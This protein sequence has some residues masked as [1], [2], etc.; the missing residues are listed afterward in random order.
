MRVLVVYCFY[1]K[2]VV[3]I[4]NLMFFL[5][6]CVG[7]GA[8]P[9]FQLDY[10]FCINGPCDID[11]VALA[12]ARAPAGSRVSS[13]KRPNEDYDFGAYSDALTAVSV[14]G[15]LPSYD[16]YF[17]LNT[18]VRGPFVPPYFKGHWLDPFVDLLVGDVHLC[19]TTINVLGAIGQS[20]EAQA[21]R[22]VT[23]WSPPFTHVQSQVFCLD[24]V[25]M[26][27]LDDEDFFSSR[28]SNGRPVQTDFVKFIAEKEI[29]MS[30]LLLR[31][32]FNIACLVPE[33]QGID[34]RSCT[35][36]I[37]PSSFSG[38][39]CF[40]G[41]C[42]GRTLHPYE[43]VFIK[44]NRGLMPAEIMSLTHAPKVRASCRE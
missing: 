42:F 27:H 34:Y 25:G 17:F 21:F 24:R 37:N 29:M 43:V 16:F 18:S 38:D 1:P 9:R 28:S 30:Q 7:W 44:V 5:D 10:H 6:Q 39:A 36:D 32:G 4:D 33:Y 19:G 40:S 14:T 35:G 8:S 12:R 2:N 31:R 23:G 26:K 3:Y 15:K 20:Q 13:I 11:V 22:D 41:A